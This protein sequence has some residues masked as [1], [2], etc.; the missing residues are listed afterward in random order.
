MSNMKFLRGMGPGV[1]VGAAI[2]VAFA[3]KG[4]SFKRTTAGKTIKAI[5]DVVEN[6]TDAM[7][8]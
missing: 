4:K 7:G 2:G 6:I 1:A 3:P 8:L 5:T